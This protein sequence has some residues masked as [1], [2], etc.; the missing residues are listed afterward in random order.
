MW[1][2]KGIE[3][4]RKGEARKRKLDWENERAAKRKWCEQILGMKMETHTGF[5]WAGRSVPCKGDRAKMVQM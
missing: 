2:R 1:E 5:D 3:R 4:N